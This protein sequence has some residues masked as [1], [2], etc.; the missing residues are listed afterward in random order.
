MLMI[1]ILVY[2]FFYIIFAI[3]LEAGGGAISAAYT[4]RARAQNLSSWVPSGWLNS[5]FPDL[6]SSNLS[7]L[8]SAKRSGSYGMWSSGLSPT[9]RPS[10]RR[11]SSGHVVL[12][13][14]ST[15]S[16]WPLHP[17]L[18]QSARLMFSFR[19][20]AMASLLVSV[21]LTPVTLRRPPRI[22]SSTM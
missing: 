4:E 20:V 9:G 2:A 10:S 21:K 14:P 12:H 6:L 18:G 19:A 8:S 16:M 13:W 11:Q 1:F 3:G 17:Q 5:I 15:S 7:T 22:M